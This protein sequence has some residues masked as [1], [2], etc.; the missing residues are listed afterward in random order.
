[1]IKTKKPRKVSDCRE[2]YFKVS[3]RAKYSELVQSPFESK[4]MDVSWNANIHIN[5]TIKE[6]PGRWYHLSI[7]PFDSGYKKLRKMYNERKRSITRERPK[8]SLWFKA[9]FLNTITGDWT[10]T[11]DPRSRIY[12]DNKPICKQVKKGNDQ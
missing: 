7:F 10:Q 8:Q 11:I 1:M 6:K 5:A 9:R 2:Q 4:D 12:F 3:K